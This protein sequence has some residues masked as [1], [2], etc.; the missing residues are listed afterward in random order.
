MGSLMVTTL[1]EIRTSSVAGDI[2]A[3]LWPDVVDIPV[4]KHNVTPY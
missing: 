2:L 4:G 1:P 3:P